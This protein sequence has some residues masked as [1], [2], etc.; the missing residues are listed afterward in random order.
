[1][2]VK[3]TGMLALTAC[4]VAGWTVAAGAGDLYFGGGMKTTSFAGDLEPGKYVDIR[5]GSGTAL[6]VGYAFD[7][8]WGFEVGASRSWIRER[9]ADRFADYLTIEAGPR[10]TPWP[11]LSYAPFVFAGVGTY[12]IDIVGVGFSGTGYFAGL[13]LENFADRHSVRLTFQGTSWTSDPEEL[14]A[15][16]FN[17][18]LVYAY[19]L[20]R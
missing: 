5:P 16:N 2:K 18:G 9:F 7:P 11:D 20:G 13:G 4:L 17:F 3:L 8:H 10:F 1:M 15:P 6:I 19:H 12:D 14:E